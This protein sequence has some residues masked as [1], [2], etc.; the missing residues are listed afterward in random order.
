[1]TLCK[2]SYLFISEFSS[3]Y[4]S[5]FNIHVKLLEKHYQLCDGK[6]HLYCYITL[7]RTPERSVVVRGGLKKLY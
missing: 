6:N 5:S 2:S 3:C 7:K 4:L 1:M